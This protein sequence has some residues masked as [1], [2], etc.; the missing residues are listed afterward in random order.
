MRDVHLVQGGD[1]AERASLDL[2][3]AV[4]DALARKAADH[5][6]Q[7]VFQELDAQAGGAVQRAVRHRARQA[8]REDGAGHARHQLGQAWS[9]T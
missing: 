1:S 9:S 5:A 4:G 6:G 3:E 7:A 8:G 2:H